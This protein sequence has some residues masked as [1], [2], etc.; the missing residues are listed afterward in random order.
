MIGGLETEADLKRWLEKE[1]RESPGV[2]RAEQV[3][4]RLVCEEF[5]AVQP[6]GGA[7]PG[8][9][10]FTNS[11]V[12]FDA[13]KPVGYMKDRMGFVHLQGYAKSGTDGTSIFTLP[14]GYRPAQEQIIPI[15]F[16][17]GGLASD[18]QYVTIATSGTVTPAALADNILVSLCGVTF[19]ADS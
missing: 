13:A 19:K 17:T 2:L 15:G 11:W 7:D 5:I 3:K 9:A 6:S 16:I 4:G 12:N 1:L 8:V 18:A 10:A 14:E